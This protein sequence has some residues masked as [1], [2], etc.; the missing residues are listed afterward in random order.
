[1]NS[2]PRN[3]IASGGIIFCPSSMSRYDSKPQAHT[4]GPIE[5]ESGIATSGA[6]GLL[7]GSLSS[8]LLEVSIPQVCFSRLE[9]Y[10][11]TVSDFSTSR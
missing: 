1:M 4:K 5:H 7:R 3:R 8:A 11:M 2:Q 10:C 9:V 6:L